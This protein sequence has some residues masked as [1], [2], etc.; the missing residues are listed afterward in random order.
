MMRITVNAIL[1]A[2]FGAEGAEFDR[3]RE[4]LP[5]FVRL[6]SRL[7]AV[8]VPQADWDDGARGAGSGPCAATTTRS[9]N[10]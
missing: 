6:A 1:R 5:P 7:V 10:G 8:P 4:L 3:L 9:S 2:V